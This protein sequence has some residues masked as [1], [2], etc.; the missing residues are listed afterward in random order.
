MINLLDG[1]IYSLNDL[2]GNNAVN[3]DRHIGPYYFKPEDPTNKIV[4][5]LT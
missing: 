5:I 1:F 2:L 4:I 3:E